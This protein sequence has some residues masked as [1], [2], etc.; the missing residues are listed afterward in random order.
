V[1]PVSVVEL[2]LDT[3]A[4]VL[5]V[6]VSPIV[7]PVTGIIQVIC[8]EP[9]GKASAQV[10]DVLGD[11]IPLGIQALPG[12]LLSILIP[13]ATLQG[14]QVKLDLQIADLVGNY[15]FYSTIIPVT[16]NPGPVL[17][18]W[19]SPAIKMELFPMAAYQIDLE[20]GR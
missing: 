17:R 14:N 18:T 16:A 11:V 3:Q 4:P 20:N 19:A 10:T 2:T 12:N 15:A 8:S 13:S 7:P 5:T 9:I 6:S 1:V